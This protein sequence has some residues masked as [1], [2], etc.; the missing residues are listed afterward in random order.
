MKKIIAVT[1]CLALVIGVAIA[2]MNYD[3]T[4]FVGYYYEK[5]E[6]YETEMAKGYVWHPT[7]EKEVFSLDE[8]RDMATYC[9]MSLTGFMDGYPYGVAVTLLSDR[10]LIFP[11][12]D[13]NQ[14]IS[15]TW[16]LTL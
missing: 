15:N 13:W 10:A 1:L 5:G 2:K 8:I 9:R 14:G 3:T 12:L 4:H 6:A 16:Y 11:G 7:G